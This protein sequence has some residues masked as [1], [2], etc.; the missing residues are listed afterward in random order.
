MQDSLVIVIQEL[1]MININSILIIIR[2]LKKVKKNQT[3]S[4]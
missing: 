3:F 1:L 4:H 2:S